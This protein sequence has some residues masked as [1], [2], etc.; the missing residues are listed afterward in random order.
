MSAAG[1]LLSYGVMLSVGVNSPSA[2]AERMTKSSDVCLSVQ[3]SLNKLRL[4]ES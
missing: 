4:S 3:L 2:A 1:R